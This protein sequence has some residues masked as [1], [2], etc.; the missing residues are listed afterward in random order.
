MTVHDM[1]QQV[2]LLS[3]GVYARDGD[4]SR[5]EIHTPGNRTQ[6]LYGR[7]QSIGDE[8]AGLLYTVV[9]R[10]KEDMDPRDLLRLNVT[11]R[12]ARL[13]LLE[14][15]HIVL[16]A[17]FDLL[18]TSINECAPILQELAA[19]ADDLEQRYFALDIS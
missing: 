7:V 14:D 3:D 18:R 12:H 4:V 16:M 5:I 13:A 19:V 6:L 10:L 11:L 8:D 17:T 1:M 15:S 9:G 2:A